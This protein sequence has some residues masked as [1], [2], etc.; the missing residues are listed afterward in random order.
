ML[1]EPGHCGIIRVSAKE[2]HI[3]LPCERGNKLRVRSWH[4][5]VLVMYNVYKRE[6]SQ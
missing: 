5:Q 2:K 3:N 6:G 4:A 1:F